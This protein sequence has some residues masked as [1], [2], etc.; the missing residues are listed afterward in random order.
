MSHDRQ[1]GDD[2]GVGHGAGRDRRPWRAPRRP[3]GRPGPLGGN[4]P[5]AAGCPPTFLLAC[6]PAGAALPPGTTLS[7]TAGSAPLLTK[8]TTPWLA[9][10]PGYS[11]ALTEKLGSGVAADGGQDPV[12]ILADHLDVAVEDHPVAGQR[13]IAVAHRMPAVMGLR[14]LDDGRDAGRARIRVHAGIDPVMQGPGI[15]GAAGD[16]AVL[17]GDV[18]TELQRQAGKRRAGLT[19]VGAVGAVVLPDDRF[20]LGRRL[21]LGH[22]AVVV[23]DIDD[24]RP[25]RPVIRQLRAGPTAPGP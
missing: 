12:G 16:P 21:A 19:V 20:H 8:P 6:W 5:P 25:Q 3:A 14:V 2:G 23:G 13:L 4:W 7:A 1:P 9:S 18:G 15:G 11:W 24:G 17:A 22:P 10:G